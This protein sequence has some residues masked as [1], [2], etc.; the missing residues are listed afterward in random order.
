MLDLSSP[1]AVALWKS[2]ISNIERPCLALWPDKGRAFKRS[3][4]SLEGPILSV[5]RRRARPEWESIVKGE[6]AGTFEK[7]VGGNGPELNAGNHQ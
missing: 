6:T 5:N 2:G 3:E 7:G 1:K 4:R